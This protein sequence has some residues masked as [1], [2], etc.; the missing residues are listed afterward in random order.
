MVQ[1]TGKYTFGHG[2]LCA[3]VFYMSCDCLFEKMQKQQWSVHMQQYQ[4]GA[5]LLNKQYDGPPMV[6][7]S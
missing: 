5:K 6:I 3:F 2:M 1:I 7:H 4:A